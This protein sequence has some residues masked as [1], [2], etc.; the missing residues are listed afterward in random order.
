MVERADEILDLHRKALEARSM[1]SKSPFLKDRKRFS[2]IADDYQR[3][4]EHLSR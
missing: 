4:A 2:D 1:A 3:R